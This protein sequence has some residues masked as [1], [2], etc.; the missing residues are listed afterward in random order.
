VGVEGDSVHDRG[1]QAGIGHD[2]SPLAE[3][4]VGAD[5]DAGAFLSFGDD[6][7]Q[8]FGSAGVDLDVAQFI[9]QQQVQ[10]GVSTDDAG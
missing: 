10:A 4:E 1:D 2:G 5:A 7:E 8:Q 9:D 6:L 3:R